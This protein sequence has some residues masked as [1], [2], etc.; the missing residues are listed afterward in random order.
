MAEK[1]SGNNDPT[2]PAPNMMN[3]VL[4]KGGATRHGTPGAP[5]RFAV[6]CGAVMA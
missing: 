2:T 4:T 5:M 3:A 1:R 6:S